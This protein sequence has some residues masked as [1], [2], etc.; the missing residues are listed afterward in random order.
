MAL[1]NYKKNVKNVVGDW[2]IATLT[3]VGRCVVI[4]SKDYLY[5]VSKE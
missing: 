3:T 2:F 4:N 1:E 5:Y